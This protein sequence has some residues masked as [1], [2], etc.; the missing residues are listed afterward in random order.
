MGV[1]FFVVN[2]VLVVIP[3]VLPGDTHLIARHTHTEFVHENRVM[4]PWNSDAH[5]SLMKIRD[6]ACA[7]GWCEKPTNG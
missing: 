2:F 5:Q 3:R 4:V 6:W 7:R 1:E